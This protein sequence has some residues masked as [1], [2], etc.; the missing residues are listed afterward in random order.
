MPLV[1]VPNLRKM[2]F[3]DLEETVIDDFTL[4]Y[5]A[6]A[7]NHPAIKE[8]LAR[9]APAEVRLFSFAL[10]NEWDV[11]QYHLM[12]KSWLNAALGVTIELGN[13]FTTETLFQQ[14]LARGLHFED[15]RECQRFHGKQFGFERYVEFS[16]EFRDMELI[17]VDDAVESG[18]YTCPERNLQVRFVNVAEL[19][20]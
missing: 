3:L 19:P 20:C 13:V 9:E 10:Q 12:F 1:E 7:R 2:V 16:P 15:S 11:K 5:G 6:L 18:A 14:C 8:F 4:G 17:L